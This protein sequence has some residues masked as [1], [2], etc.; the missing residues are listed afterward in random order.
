MSNP[1]SH[2][3][4]LCTGRPI[5]FLYILEQMSNVLNLEKEKIVILDKEPT[6]Y[7]YSG[8][9]GLF[10]REIFPIEQTKLTTCITELY[11]WYAQ[12]DIQYK[13]S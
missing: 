11:E 1:S 3:Y 12:Q 8:D 4:N 5:S 7:E 2:I 10:C 13:P 6:T 9:P